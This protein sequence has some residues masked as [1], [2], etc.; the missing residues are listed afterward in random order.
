[1]QNRIRH[2]LANW[3]PEVL[4][5]LPLELGAQPEAQSADL[6]NAAQP[7]SGGYNMPR[8]INMLMPVEL[9]INRDLLV[10]LLSASIRE[11][12]GHKRALPEGHTSHELAEVEAALQQQLTFRS[13][14]RHHPGTYIS[15]GMFPVSET[16][17]IEDLED[18][19]DF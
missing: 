3:N 2:L 19:G 11:I 16:K 14:A 5:P 10:S 1:M 12:Q 9:C 7:Q 8:G 4:R 13:W 18:M 15:I 6:A 17:S